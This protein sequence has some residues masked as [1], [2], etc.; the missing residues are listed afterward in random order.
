MRKILKKTLKFLAQKV[1]TRYKPIVIGVTGSVGKTSAKEA[2]FSALSYKFWVAKNEQNF[3]NELGVPM[4]VLRI[5]PHYFKN[6]KLKLALYLGESLFK[7]FWLTFGWPKQEYPKFL[8]LELAADKPRD[9]E[10]LVDTVKPNVGV[11]SAVGDI[12]VHVEF[13]ASPQEVAKE[14]SKLISSLPSSGGLAVLNYDDQ[15]V[16]DMREKTSAKIMT[17][18]F[19]NNADIWASDT[20][21]FANENND[22]IGGLSFKINSGSTFV[23]VRVNNLV[24][25][26]QIYSI[27]AGAAV[28]M[29]FGLNLID[30]SKSI[31]NIELPH[32]RMNLSRGIKE[33][34]IIDDTYNASPL[35]M[36]AALDTLRDFA[37]ARESFGKK[38]RRIAILGDMKELGKYEVNAHHRVGNLAGERCDVLIT[39]GLAAKFIAD[40]AVDQMSAEKIMSFSNSEDARL[41]IKEVIQE[42]DVVLV[43]GSR[44][45]KMEKIVNE[46]NIPQ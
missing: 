42:N 3:N 35:S 11:V 8:V 4:A 1:I 14:K 45:M 34:A 19:S 29:H 41:K 13:Y 39:V 10:Y 17:F 23:P 37:K 24:G 9:I 6:S 27:L 16:L 46:I 2:I 28:G 7:A 38:G 22:S 18:G 32:H 26:H 43:K 15:T 21:Y 5:K 33:T 31:E 25:L 30:I 40:S 44:S 20:S 36:H 12:P